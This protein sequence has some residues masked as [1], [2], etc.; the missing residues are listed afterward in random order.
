M[1]EYSITDH[2]FP[3]ISNTGWNLGFVVSWVSRWWAWWVG[4]VEGVFVVA[5]G[6]GFWELIVYP[7]CILGNTLHFFNKVFI[8]Y[9]KK[10]E[11]LELAKT[12]KRAPKLKNRKPAEGYQKRRYQQ[13]WLRFRSIRFGYG[14]R[15][16]L[17]TPLIGLGLTRVKESLDRVGSGLCAQE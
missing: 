17:K 9:I 3:K 5:R 11:P 4:W 13:G 1:P 7:A 12:C 8:S 16:F 10:K 15:L 2:N 6:L 14:P